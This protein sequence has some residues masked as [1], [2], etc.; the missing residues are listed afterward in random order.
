MAD[1]LVVDLD[2]YRD[3]HAPW[4]L[5]LLDRLRAD[6]GDRFRVTLF[7]IPGRTGDATL[8]A[9]KDRPWVEIAAHGWTHEGPECADWTLPRA[10]EVLDA[11][12]S[13]GYAKVFK[14]PHWIAAPATYVA[15]R[16]RDWA[17][18][19]HPRNRLTIPR[20]LRR[21]VLADDHRI[22]VPHGI[23]PVIQAHGHFTQEGVQ[24]GLRENLAIFASLAQWGLPYAFVSEVAT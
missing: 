21:Y 16:E 9:L 6:S 23:L 8:Q 10:L 1:K 7:T 4:A 22:G 12:E 20:G 18:A 15:L 11:C 3:T 13:A 2:D 17:I 5:P 14:A 19:D 24:N